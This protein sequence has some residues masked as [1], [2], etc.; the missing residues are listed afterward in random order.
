MVRGIASWITA[1]R[2]GLL[3]LALVLGAAALFRWTLF[4]PNVAPPGSDGGQWLAFGYQLLGGERIKAGFESYPPLVPFI[5][6]VAARILPP[7]ITLKL[8]GVASATLISIALYPLVRVWLGPR[9]SGIMAGAVAFAPYQSEIL[10]F[11]GYPQLAGTGLSVFTLFF[12][13]LALDRRRRGLFVLAGILAAATVA[14]HLLAAVQL[15]IALPV[16][17]GLHLWS[18]RRDRAAVTGAIRQFLMWT[19]A[20]AALLALPVLPSYSEYLTG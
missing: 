16:V 7:L 10:M 9:M 8:V 4:R 5:V 15:G 1:E 6:G 19:A 12:L 20:P 3:V 14:A 13:A 17:L 2:D 11:G 18:V